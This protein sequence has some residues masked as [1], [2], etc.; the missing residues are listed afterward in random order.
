MRKLLLLA[1]VI[2]GRLFGQEAPF[3][4]SPAALPG[5]IICSAYD[6]GGQGVGFN[7]LA[8]AGWTVAATYRTDGESNLKQNTDTTTANPWVTGYGVT[9]VWTKYTVNVPAAAAFSFA[10]RC[11]SAAGGAFHLLV[12]GTATSSVKVPVVGAWNTPQEWTTLAVPGTYNLEVGTHVIEIFIDSSNVDMNELIAT[13]TGPMALPSG[14]Y[15]LPNGSSV[16]VP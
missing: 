5:T 8:D 1:L 15:I 9:G 14:N 13:A 10:F 4:G 2:A 3:G 6:T 12:D 16:T 11:G 7:F